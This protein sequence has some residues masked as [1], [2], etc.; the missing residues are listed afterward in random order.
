MIGDDYRDH[1]AR[2]TNLDIPKH[3]DSYRPAVV[4]LLARVKSHMARE[5]WVI[6]SLLLPP[7]AVERMAARG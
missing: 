6:E 1:V 7:S 3:W 4:R 2:C 5:R